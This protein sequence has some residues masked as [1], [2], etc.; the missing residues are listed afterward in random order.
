MLELLIEDTLLK[1]IINFNDVE[2]MIVTYD[3]SPIQYVEKWIENFQV[4]N[5]NDLQ[6]LFFAKRCLA[7]KAKLLIQSVSKVNSW[8]KF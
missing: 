1:P 2:K 7:G 6:E 8:K 5:L 4:F 3:G